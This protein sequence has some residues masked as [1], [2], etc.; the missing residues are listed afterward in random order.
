MMIIF[1]FSNGMSFHRGI[2]QFSI[3]LFTNGHI[4]NNFLYRPCI[5]VTKVE[6]FVNV[7]FVGLFDISFTFCKKKMNS[8]RGI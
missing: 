8:M 3:P 1:F 6:L 7:F 2:P 4:F 5:D